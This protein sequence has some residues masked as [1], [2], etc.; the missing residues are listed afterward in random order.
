MG[1]NNYTFKSK[2]S[3]IDDKT[4]IELFIFNDLKI[5]INNKKIINMPGE[6]FPVKYGM[7]YG[8]LLLDCIGNYIYLKKTNP[9]LKIIFFKYG[10]V[11]KNKV[12]EDL[13]L[14]FNAESINIFNN[15]YIFEKFLFFYTEDLRNTLPEEMILNKNTN[16]FLPPIPSKLFLEKGYVV[17]DWSK[18]WKL[19]K[20]KSIESLCETFD[21]YKIKNNKN[22]IYVSRTN[23]FARTDNYS[24]TSWFKKIKERSPMY[25]QNLNEIME[26]KGYKIVYPET[27]GFFEQI[28]LFNN[29]TDVV[30]IDGTSVL[31]A[32][33]CENDSNITR[34]M[35][36]KEYKK[37]NYDWS[38]L[39]LASGNKNINI[40]DLTDLEPQH[41]I[42]IIIKEIR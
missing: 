30:T 33:W 18:E 38:T 25:D 11:E 26:N 42:D 5:L 39:I 41:G 37:L 1:K 16:I 31:N 8:H 21:K 28:N 15:N 2:S 32:I 29:A 12:C 14:F 7:H 22:K 35:V 3:I 27:M 17:D 4:G 20:I 24:T 34:I 13:M 36:N 10:D 40:L 23:D 6:Y 19:L 9:N